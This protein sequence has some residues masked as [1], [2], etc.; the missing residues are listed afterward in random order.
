LQVA[1]Q[2]PAAQ[3]ERAGGQLHAFGQHCVVD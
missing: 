3:P 1:V 2:L